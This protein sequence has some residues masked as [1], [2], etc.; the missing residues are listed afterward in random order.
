MEERATSALMNADGSA[1]TRKRFLALL[2]SRVSRRSHFPHFL[3]YQLVPNGIDA[4][5]LLKSDESHTCEQVSFRTV[6]ELNAALERRFAGCVGIALLPKSE[7]LIREVEV[8]TAAIDHVRSM[9][10]LEAE[11]CVPAEFGDVELS[12]VRLPCQRDGYE[13]CELY[14][15]RRQTVEK[16]LEPASHLNLTSTMVLPTAVVWRQLVSTI[17]D[18]DVILAEL[19]GCQTLEIAWRGA[20]GGLRARAVAN[21][22]GGT[23]VPV[24]VAACLRSAISSLSGDGPLKVGWLVSSPPSFTM[25]TGI[26][27]RDLALDGS[28]SVG[29][30]LSP[31]STR[32]LLA[33]SVTQIEE[34]RHGG[35]LASGGMTL[36]QA[37]E[38]ERRRTV[39]RY[40]V[41]GALLSM[42]GTCLLFL[43]LECMVYRYRRAS[44]LLTQQIAVIANEGKAVGRQLQQL[45]AA[46]KARATQEDFLDVMSALYVATPE[47]VTYGQV[48][49]NDAGRIR[50]RGQAESLSLPFLLPREL[51]KSEV[52]GQVIVRG[53]GQVSRQG[54]TITEFTVD[55]ILQR[56]AIP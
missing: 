11:A 14:V 23:E 33:A 44:E 35:Q 5:Y 34:L 9:L 36:A 28:A 16:W 46:R 19:P 12:Y 1:T 30:K 53:A 13:R 32:S 15:A 42:V 20:Q 56:R 31:S 37:S 22:D 40:I 52:I 6:G 26:I 39:R 21:T 2:R 7:Y 4:A 45:E 24:S 38:A 17:S 8:P 55:C 29:S 50:L 10:R 47:G 49:M 41:A 25:P 18:V 3:V 27:I 54:S 48:E 51:D 43:A